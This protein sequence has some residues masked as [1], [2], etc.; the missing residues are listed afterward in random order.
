MKLIETYRIAAI[1]L[2]VFFLLTGCSVRKNTAGSRFYHAFTTRYNV[3]F[4]GQEAYEAGLQAQESGN[5]DNYLQILP[6]YPI[7]NQP[8]VLL[9]SGEFERAIEKAQKAIRQHSIKRKPTRTPGRA[10]TETYK[11]W[12]KRRE[13]NPF[14]HH[15]WMLLGKA[16]YQKG[17]FE[18]A[19]VTF[20]YIARL[21]QGQTAISTEA[22][23]RLAR[24]YS[25]LGWNYDA[26]DLLYR[27]NSDTLPPSLLDEYTSALSNHLLSSGRYA[28]AIPHLEHAVQQKQSRLQRARTYYLLGQLYQQAQRNREAFAAYGKVIRLNPPYQLSFS[29]RIRQTEVMPRERRQA[30]QRRLLRMSREEKNKDFTDQIYYALGNISL[31][32]KDTVDAIRAYQ[33][34][35]ER[36]VRNGVEKGILYL[37]LGNLQW[38]RG[39][40][41]SAQQAY[42]GAIGTL[43][44]EHPQY[45]ELLRRSEALDELVPHLQ[46]IHLQDSLQRI[47]ALPEAERLLL[48]QQHIDKVIAQEEAEKA[49]RKDAEREEL[50]QQVAEIFAPMPIETK[51]VLS[52]SV[53]SNQAWYFYN[54]QLVEQGKT[55]FLRQW[56]QRKLEDNWRRRNKTV[57]ALDEFEA[58]NYEEDSSVH[59]VEDLETIANKNHAVDSLSNIQPTLQSTD[60]DK[61]QP[62]Y[63]LKQLPLSEEALASSN[64]Q[65]TEALYQAG[66]LFKERL[67]DFAR[68]QSSLT[69][70]LNH[71]PH[72]PHRDA[73]LYQLFL[74]ELAVDY[75]QPAPKSPL[76]AQQAERYRQQ[77]L[78]ESPDSRYALVVGDPDYVENARYGKQREDSL[79]TETYQRYRQADYKGVTQA[80]NVSALRYPNGRHR[81]KFLFLQAASQLQQG[82][83]K[84]FLEGLKVLVK[85]YPEAEISDLAAHVL[86]GVQEGRLLSKETQTFG[87][88][89]KR[90]HVAADN[91]SPLL[92]DTLGDNQ[93]QSDAFSDAR[94][95]EYLFLLAYEEGSVDENRLLYEVARYNFSSFLVKNFDLN[96]VHERGIGMLCISPFNNYDEAHHYFRRL[97]ADVSMAQRLTGLRAVVISKENYE[98]LLAQY[99]FEEYDTF[100]RTHFAT[101]PEPQIEGYT[102]DEP[103]QNILEE[104]ESEEKTEENPSEKQEDEENG[105]IFED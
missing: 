76:P 56:G 68:A 47:A 4:N 21:Y 50:K 20:A 87:S 24:C 26:E 5:Q 53:S 65:L 30:I 35:I 85:T 95:G 83:Q 34:G 55:D 46:T 43:G 74:L 89:W 97:Y 31:S 93:L 14:L 91:H 10:Y 77:L 27:V 39:E 22:L 9:G 42:N 80:C 69:R 88:I 7:G 71:Y 86:K 29:A 96:F 45:Q 41:P 79:Y 72:Y 36:S 8:T 33:T 13:F 70:L 66:R 101:I 19:A 63:Y 37:T 54:P 28:E 82:N 73:L 49:A 23:I 67:Q 6:L 104:E 52:T 11:Q 48:I 105:V 94:S 38:S 15:A 16:Q 99:S 84:E 59:S 12:L 64:A 102:L 3:Y 25:A 60:T 32:A 61:Y 57:V 58:Y 62:A 92:N 81:S 103:L 90:R 17:L 40:Y 18:E 98:R 100:F 44:K 2:A 1:V 75:Y 78:K 51:P